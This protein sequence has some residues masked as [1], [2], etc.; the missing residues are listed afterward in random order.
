MGGMPVAL[1]RAPPVVSYQITQILTT[2]PPAGTCGLSA[3]C[4]RTVCG[5]AHAAIRAPTRTTVPATLDTF[6]MAPHALCPIHAPMIQQTHATA[7]LCAIMTEKAGTAARVTLGTAE[8]AHH[9]L[10]RTAVRTAHAILELTATTS[11]RPSPATPAIH[12]LMVST[13]TA[14]PAR[15]SMT[16]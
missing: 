1:R 11:L 15:T 7:T 9:A 3:N 6:S 16:V 4:H 14:R 10:T 5:P 13:A 2:P 12:A 8:M